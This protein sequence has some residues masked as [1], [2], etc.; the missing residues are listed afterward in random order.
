[1]YRI[2]KWYHFSS[3]RRW[4]L[5]AKNVAHMILCIII[6]HN[7]Q[8]QQQKNNKITLVM[9]TNIVECGQKCR[10]TTYKRFK[11]YDRR[12]RSSSTLGRRR[13]IFFVTKQC[14]PITNLTASC[15]IRMMRMLGLKYT[16]CE[17]NSTKMW[18]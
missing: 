2:G 9:H 6:V 8:Q 17:I 7:L 16:I 1:M 14:C 18:R 15:T 4:F 13:F 5:E 10:P 12:V 11:F 3:C